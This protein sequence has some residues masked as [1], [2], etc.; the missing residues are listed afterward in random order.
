MKLL[1][2]ALLLSMSVHARQYIQCSDAN[3]WDRMVVNLDAENSTLFMTTGV[4]DPDALNILKDLKLAAS[5]ESFHIYET[6]GEIIESIEIPNEFIDVYANYFLVQM[7]LT[8]S[9]TGSSRTRQMSCFS[10]LYDN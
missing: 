9:S 1:L 2:A 5:N 6:Q 3:S 7:T 10:A 4:H 8:N